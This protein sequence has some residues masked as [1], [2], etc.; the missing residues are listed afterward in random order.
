MTG[1]QRVLHVEDDESISAIARVALESIG[2][3]QV[4]SCTSGRM[5]V[6]QAAAFEPDLLLIDVMMPGMDGPAT[7]AALAGVIDLVGVP[8]VFMTA[9][10]Q[11][12][13]HQ[14]YIALGATAVIVKP[15]DPMTLAGKLESIWTGFHGAQSG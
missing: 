10:T 8:V 13:D 4:L 5:A 9:K 14:S 12:A 15:F 3:L 6:E 7:L 1:L 2:G 11:P